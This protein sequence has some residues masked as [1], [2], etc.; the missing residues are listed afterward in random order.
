MS[1]R[2]ILIK[3]LSKKPQ[4]VRIPDEVPRPKKFRGP[5]KI[6][7]E[8]CIGCGICAY[9]CVSYAVRLT[10]REG[11][12]EWQYLPGK[13]TFCGLCA[14]VCPANALRNENGG[15]PA[16]SQAEELNE[17]HMVRYPACPDCGKPAQPN[18]EPVLQRAFD[19]LTD[20]L[21][22]RMLLCQKCRL[23]RSQSELRISAGITRRHDG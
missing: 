15:V 16:Y 2:S 22:E 19:K 10:E 1:V 7:V 20:E 5:V 13:C 3:N 23:K 12:C 11:G 21:R 8:K 9:V 6:D 4:T 14:M 17:V 18:V